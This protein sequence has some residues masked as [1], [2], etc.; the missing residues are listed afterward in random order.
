MLLSPAVCLRHIT[1]DNNIVFK[2][3]HITQEVEGEMENKNHKNQTKD[4]YGKIT[5]SSVRVE[6]SSGDEVPQ[7]LQ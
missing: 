2:K 5:K 7:S 4:T 1:L 3:K 6:Y